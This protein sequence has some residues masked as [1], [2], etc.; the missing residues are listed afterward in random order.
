MGDQLK[1]ITLSFI[2]HISVFLT[3]IGISSSAVP[4][5]K[6][7]VIDFTFEDSTGDEEVTLQTALPSKG[8]EKITKEMVEEIVNPFPAKEEKPKIEKEVTVYES[9]VAPSISEAQVPVPEAMTMEHS[10][11]L[12]GKEHNPVAEGITGSSSMGREVNVASAGGSG[13]SVERAKKKY[14]KTN[15]VYIRD[16]IMKN[17]FYPYEAR[18]M[19]W[20][21]KV[22]VSFV[23]G[24]NGYVDSIKIINSSGFEVLDKSVVE[25]IK[26]VCPFPKPPVEALIVLPIVYKLN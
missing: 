8:Y 23:V 10:A 5:S 14:L 17:I 26:M 25:T 15:F 21:G 3:M 7:I 12:K 20:E 18:R 1:G 16:L 24:K 4:M 2:I 6:P 19:G 13:D 22:T 11:D 9:P